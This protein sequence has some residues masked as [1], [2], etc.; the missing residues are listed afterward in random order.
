ME[1]I[2]VGPRRID[3]DRPGGRKYTV[4]PRQ[5][6]TVRYL[7]G[8]NERKFT[9]ILL[10]DPKFNVKYIKKVGKKSSAV[11]SLDKIKRN[12]SKSQYKQWRTEKNI[13]HYHSEN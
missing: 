11:K 4:L 8:P 12:M 7:D 1:L 5:A 10:D 9:T 3:W 6:A 13:P 2:D